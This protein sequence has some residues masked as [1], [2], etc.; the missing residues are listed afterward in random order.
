MDFICL[1]IA[2]GLF[3]LS[4]GLIALCDRLSGS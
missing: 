3:A 4:F 2:A 1:G